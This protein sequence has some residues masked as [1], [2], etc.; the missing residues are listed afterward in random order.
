MSE[1][2]HFGIASLVGDWQWQFLSLG[3]GID[4]GRF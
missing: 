4:R 2:H 1:L 3:I